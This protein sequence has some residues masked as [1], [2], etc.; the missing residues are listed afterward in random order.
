M[1]NFEKMLLEK[2]IS[3]I[4]E[5]CKITLCKDVSNNSITIS[6]SKKYFNFNVSCPISE[7]YDK[8]IKDI[9]KNIVIL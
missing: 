6:V 9:Y 1:L 7:E 2:I 3:L 8:I 5:G 4:E